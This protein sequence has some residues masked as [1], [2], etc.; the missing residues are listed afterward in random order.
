MR[1]SKAEQAETLS[2]SLLSLQE[3][4]ERLPG[5]GIAYLMKEAGLTVSGFYKHVRFSVT[6]EWLSVGGAL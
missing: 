2:A 3:F 5:S 6:L 1:H 4:R